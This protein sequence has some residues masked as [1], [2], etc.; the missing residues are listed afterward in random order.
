MYA[1]VST[2]FQFFLLS[3]LSGLVS[4][5]LYDILRISRRIVRVSDTVINIEDILFFA[6]AAF[7]I[8]IAA[9]LKNSGE[10]RWQSFIGFAIGITLYIV[11]V[12]NR[13]LNLSTVI[14]RFIVKIVG[15]VISVIL[16]PLRLIFK[17]FRKPVSVIAWYTGKGMR[18]VKSAAKKRRIKFHIMLK[19]IFFMFGKQK[20]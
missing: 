9:Y 10:I 16:F 17:I 5:F 4:A 13:L 11:T 8:F 6:A 14:I 3:I 15:M 7:L 2:E 1:S 19:N 12:R 18:R 20:K